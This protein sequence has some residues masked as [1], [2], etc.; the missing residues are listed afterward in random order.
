[1]QTP[2]DLLQMCLNILRQIGRNLFM[3]LFPVILTGRGSEFS[4][5][6]AIELG[7]DLDDVLWTKVFSSENFIVSGLTFILKNPF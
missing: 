6:L 7:K 1:M 5:P 3:R 4:N 2:Q